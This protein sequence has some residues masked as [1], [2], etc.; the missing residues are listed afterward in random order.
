MGIELDDEALQKAITTAIIQTISGD[1]RDELFSSA[2]AHLIDDKIQV[3]DGTSYGKRTISRITYA[4]EQAVEIVARRTAIEILE[5]EPAKS[6]V[7]A[8]MDKALE[9]ALEI[10]ADKI[11][12]ELANRMVTALIAGMG[13]D[14]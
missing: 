7:R 9:Q 13:R 14:Y 12:E 10:Q 2:V 6:K 4:F 5:A 8:I 1:K 11:T 3:S